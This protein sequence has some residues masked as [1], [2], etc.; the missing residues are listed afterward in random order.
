[1]EIISITE[2]ENEINLYPPIEN[3]EES[4][5]NKTRYIDG[6]IYKD[7]IK[8]KLNFEPYTEIAKRCSMNSIFIMRSA[9]TNRFYI[10]FLNI[11]GHGARYEVRPVR[12]RE[13]KNEQYIEYMFANHGQQLDRGIDLNEKYEI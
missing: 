1:M 12:L 6:E 10:G 13:I 7:L 3:L 5:Y 9:R 2:L 11:G 4:S 8:Y